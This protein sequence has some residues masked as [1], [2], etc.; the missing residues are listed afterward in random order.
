LEN[1]VEDGAKAALGRLLSKEDRISDLIAFLASLDPV[2]LLGV[3]GLTTQTPSVKREVAVGTKGRR[4]RADLIVYDGTTPIALIEIKAASA[5]HGEQFAAYEG[6]RGGLPHAVKCFAVSLDQKISGLPD[7]WVEVSLP[8]VLNSWQVSTNLHAQWLATSAASTLENWI[9]QANGP[10]GRARHTVVADLVMRKVAQTL[11]E[12]AETDQAG[13]PSFEV[14]VGRDS[15]GKAAAT[16]HRPLNSDNAW[17]C[18]VIRAGSRAD[19][20]AK[21][22]LRCGVQVGKSFRG[23]IGEARA[24]AHDLALSMRESITL[25]ALT[26]HLETV[27]RPELAQALLLPS[28]NADGLRREPTGA[29]LETWRS[30]M[31][32]GKAVRN[33][34]LFYQDW[35]RRLTSHILIDVTKI[36]G[37]Q[38]ADLMG[39][40]LN[41]LQLSLSAT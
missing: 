6:W 15:G 33:H 20:S 1:E 14:W 3:L 40:A 9:A 13:Q 35:G 24:A 10:I 18:V 12:S 19:P 21:W 23:S 27:G 29:E 17:L 16:L 5:Q 30:D 4:G 31:V 36:D 39:L 37:Q 22:S 2:P 8:Y 25:S 38:L 34:P 41:R 7:S 28:R 32:A 11:T 26:E